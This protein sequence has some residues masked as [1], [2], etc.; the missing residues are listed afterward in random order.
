[1][2][3]ITEY[4]RTYIKI[5]DVL[6]YIGGIYDIISIFFHLFLIILLKKLLLLELEILLFQVIVKL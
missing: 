4:T 2:D 1:M 5:Q 6:S 3:L